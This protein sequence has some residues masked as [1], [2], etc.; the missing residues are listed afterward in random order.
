VPFYSSLEIG[1]QNQNNSEVSNSNLMALKN[2]SCLPYTNFIAT[3][4]ERC[5]FF[6]N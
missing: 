6:S 4:E 3:K 2:F 1:F 5:E